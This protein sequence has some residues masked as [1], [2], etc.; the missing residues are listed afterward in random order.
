MNVVREKDLK[1]LKFLGSGGYG[2]V[3]LVELDGIKYA[4]KSFKNYFS[5][6]IFID[7]LCELTHM[8]FNERYLIPLYMVE[9][10]AGTIIGYLTKYDEHLLDIEDCFTRKQRIKLLKSAKQSIVM[11]HEKYGYIHG[12]AHFGN[13]LCHDKLLKSYLIDFD[14]SVKIG[15]KPS[16]FEGYKEILQDYLK[17]YSFDQKVDIFLF[18]LSCLHILSEKVYIDD[19]FL[20]DDIA[21]NKIIIPEMNNNIK[22]LS[23][24]LLLRNTKK[25]YSGEYIIDYI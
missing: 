16:T 17:Y 11:L 6:S 1:S 18:N 2:F 3:E 4:F 15:A 22:N 13:I 8:C 9:N 19:Y 23:K 14:L 24:E 21:E 10:S 20:L 7:N 25:S 12:D 5:D